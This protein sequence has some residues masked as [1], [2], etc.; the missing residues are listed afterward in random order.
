MTINATSLK[1]GE[2]GRIALVGILYLAAVAT[3]ETRDKAASMG[4]DDAVGKAN[5]IIKQIN[6]WLDVARTRGAG[7]VADTIAAR[8]MVLKNKG[9]HCHN[10]AA[11][12]QPEELPLAI[13]LDY[14]AKTKVSS[15]LGGVIPA[16]WAECARDKKAA[17]QP[18]DDNITVMNK[19]DAIAVAKHL[20]DAL[21]IDEKNIHIIGR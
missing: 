21:G 11:K 8:A 3:E 10:C 13:I 14:C 19:D 2:V 15:L 4:D 17:E 5:N 6:E 9:Y 18:M 1:I 20:A 16:E 12:A 7:A